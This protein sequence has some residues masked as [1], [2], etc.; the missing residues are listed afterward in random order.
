M[1]DYKTTDMAIRGGWRHEY[2]DMAM[3]ERCFEEMMNL[4][5]SSPTVFS[6]LQ[7]KHLDGPR[8]LKAS[9]LSLGAGLAT[10]P[11]RQRYKTMNLSWLA[12]CLLIVIYAESVLYRPE[13]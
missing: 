12:G 13:F 10:V 11:Q 2:T 4:R 1:L 3:L 8:R 6:G 7:P 5:L 9:S